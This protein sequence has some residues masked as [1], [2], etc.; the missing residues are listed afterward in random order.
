LVPFYSAIDTLNPAELGRLKLSLTPAENGLIIN[1]MAERAETIEMVRRNLADLEKAFSEMGHEN[2]TFSFDQHDGF[3]DQATRQHTEAHSDD[4]D[5]SDQ[6]TLIP[7]LSIQHPH[8]LTAP[9]GIDI[10]V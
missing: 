6:V 3:K 10:R 4:V 5:R 9:V 8:D 2:I 7:K 1:V